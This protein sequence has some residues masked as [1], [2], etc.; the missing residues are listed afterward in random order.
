V[1]LACSLPKEFRFL[2]SMRTFSGK[3]VMSLWDLVLGEL[4]EME[5]NAS[6]VTVAESDFDFRESVA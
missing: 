2:S 3:L 1:L 5:W 6:P 4:A